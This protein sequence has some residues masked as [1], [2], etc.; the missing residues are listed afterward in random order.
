V[1]FYDMTPDEIHICQQ[2][3][4]TRRVAALAGGAAVSSEVEGIAGDAAAG[5]EGTE[6]VVAAGVVAEAVNDEECRARLR[7]LAAADG[8][9]GAVAVQQEVQLQVTVPN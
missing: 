1:A 9:T 6:L 2:R 8:D 5:G 7:R 4:N 3:G